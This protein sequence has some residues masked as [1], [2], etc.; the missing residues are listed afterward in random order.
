[1]IVHVCYLNRIYIVNDLHYGSKILFK[2]MRNI[3]HV[4]RIVSMYFKSRV[5]NS[6]DPDQMALSEA[7]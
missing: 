3:E 2:K 1:M 5:E 4:I 6:V 7:S